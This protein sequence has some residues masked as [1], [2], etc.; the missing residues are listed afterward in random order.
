M[1]FKV[2]F[3]VEAPKEFTVKGT[4]LASCL[5]KLK[6]LHKVSLFRKTG[7]F[8]QRGDELIVLQDISFGHKLEETTIVHIVQLESI[9]GSIMIE[10]VLL[11]SMGVTMSQKTVDSWKN[12][13][14]TVVPIVA[15]LMGPSGIL[16]QLGYAANSMYIMNDMT[17]PDIAV[18][19]QEATQHSSNLF[20]GA[21]IIR[22]QG[23]IT[24]LIF[25]NPFA[26]GVLINSSILTSDLVA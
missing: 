24:P 18:A 10:S 9:S 22:E 15:L 7:L 12:I 11:N 19:Q 20:N 17:R 6:H 1:I 2:W 23:G 14:D 16:L 5:N 25:G 3:T 13:L 26:G 21:T 8:I 4:N